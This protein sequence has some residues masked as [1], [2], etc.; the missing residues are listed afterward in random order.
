MQKLFGFFLCIFRGKKSDIIGG[1]LMF[2]MQCFK[3]FLVSACELGPQLI[4]WMVLNWVSDPG[5]PC[6]ESLSEVI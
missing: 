2:S 3:T 5:T 4:K 1:W 6:V